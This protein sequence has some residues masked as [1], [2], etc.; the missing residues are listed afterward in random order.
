MRNFTLLTVVF[1]FIFANLSFSQ[2]MTITYH[3]DQPV[4]I[5][6]DD[7]YSELLFN[8]CYSFGEEGNPLLPYYGADLLLQQ[9]NEITNIEILST[10]YS[11]DIFDITIKPASKQFPISKGPDGEYKVVP[12]QD[13][14]SSNDPYP[15]EVI[16]NM[17][18]GFLAGHSIGSFSVCPV[19]YFPANNKVKF[20]EEITILI[21]TQETVKATNATAF[22]KQS[23][24]TTERI[25]KIV[26]NKEML[27]KYV[28]PSTKDEESDI[29]LITKN[30]L[31]SAFDDY[32]S[33]KES[34]GFIV[35]V[36]TTEEIYSQ[37]SGQDDQD[38]IRNC[39][40]D[41]YD[42]Y[43]LEYVILG[44]DSDPTNASQDIIP[45]R[46][47]FAVDDN[48]IPSDMYYCCL[49]GNW[50]DDGD[51]KWGEPGEYDLYA[52]V[53]IGRICVDN[54][55]EI[56]NFT[57]KLKMYQN[58]PVIQDTEKALMIGEELNNNPW[59]FGGDYKDEIAQGASN[60]GLVT[61]GISNNFEIDYL[62]ER[63]M[64]WNKYDVFDMF[65]N[66]GVNLL[67]H[68][69]HSSPD[70][71]MKMYTSD[72]TTNNFQNDGVTR[73][74]VIG[75]S[76][77]CYNGA[78]D[79]R[80]WNHY[81]GADCFAEKITTIATAE[82]ASVANSRYGW[83]QPGG[84]NSTSQLCDRQ[85]YDAIFGEDITIIGFTNSDSKEDLASNFSSSDY[86]RWTV[87]ELNLFGD[88]SMDIWTET[89]VDIIASYPSSLPIGS[90]EM[91]VQTDAPFARIGI[92]QNDELIGRAVAN[93]SGDATVEFI[94]PVTN[95][96]PIEISIIAHNKNRH[97]GSLV[98]VS[99]QPF[100]L[101]DSYEVNDPSG[102]GNG[103]I[104]FGE[105]IDLGLGVK[106]VGDQPASNVVVTLSSDCEYVSITD[107]TETYG[108]F[109]PGQTIFIDDAFA[110][111][112]AENI[113]DNY[114]IQFNV[115]AAGDSTWNSNFS[116][117]ACAPE[118]AL[119]DYIISDPDGNNN[120]RL[121][122]GETVNI[123]FNVE[124]IG[125]S[126]APGTMA[127]IATSSG[128]I[129]FNNATADL[130][131]LEAGESDE[132]IF[133]LTVDPAAPV[134]VIA[135]LSME[136]SS[137]YYSA[138]SDYF[139]K[140]GL[141]V[142]D[143][144]T[145]GF[146]QY[147]WQSGGHAD[148]EIT[149]NNPYEGTYCAKSGEID[150]NQFSILMLSYEAMFN[151]SIS[152][153][154]KVSSEANYDYLK[155]YID[156]DVVG[157]WA[158]NV[159]WQRVSFPISA[160]DHNLKW[161]YD[162]DTYVS[163]GAD[164]VWIDFVELP[165]PLVTTASA[166]MDDAICEGNTYL[167][168]GSA[169]NYNSV[170]WSTSGTGSF[171]NTSVL[172]PEYTP[173]N[174]DISNGS[175][176]LTLTVYGPGETITDNMQ[177][178][179]SLSPEISITGDAEICAND[180]FVTSN[181]SALNFNNVTWNTSGDGVFSDNTV[182]E[183]TYTSGTNDIENGMVTLT[184]SADAL[185]GC[186]DIADDFMLTIHP[187]PVVELG[188]D[189][190]ICFD[191]SIILD[192]GNPG[193]NYL[194]STNETT[195]T[196][197]ASS[198]GLIEIITYWAEVTDTFGCMD[199]DEITV[200]FEEC[201]GISENNNSRYVQ[202]VPNPNSG[203]FKIRC[204]LIIQNPVDVSV[205]NPLSGIVYERSDVKADQQNLLDIQLEEISSGIYFLRISNSEINL[206]KKIII[207][208]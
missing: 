169:T 173:S 42:S 52:E 137:G 80:D 20:L 148:W 25:N 88:P 104:D 27:E 60:N 204:D 121:D 14:Y 201:A 176:V 9:G 30:S 183:T 23:F 24:L 99:N 144:E 105:Q 10:T 142:E 197:E 206:I 16:E 89:P 8:D 7:G 44:G 48:D 29:L 160:G 200:S 132:A 38:K 134:G 151:D 189:T 73:G 138:Q 149:S 124:N 193:S 198:G 92:L 126:D 153:Y 203:S 66:S 72:I 181:V 98:V 191:Q 196:I 166:G 174:D 51:G 170:E 190:A 15:S 107:N 6:N 71:N 152:F 199:S 127:E 136:I 94:N 56:L 67:N 96:N 95:S 97:T 162:K 59:T 131:V 36:V 54:S 101:F 141:I 167:C 180:E 35:S 165:T 110:F 120:G 70:Y 125:Q 85:F 65:N 195:Q 86:M 178:D 146:G 159:P 154:V 77:G 164:C 147:E 34:T 123:I 61:T 130:E 90:F 187:L 177:L 208:D 202:I 39:I 207:Q 76:Q 26:E 194:W 184:I 57:H 4:I 114:N 133:S 31:V 1:S 2:E 78:M 115:E 43:N 63:D 172:N 84:T 91:A 47:F 188:S 116:I 122:P 113:P 45:H 171:S 205:Y 108:N 5:T 81:Y 112:V 140:I 69:G 119:G 100:V 117:M 50:N 145:G 156:S 37:Y 40:I 155:F 175:V 12:N 163:T 179:I 109:T 87:Y 79:N 103:L 182:L 53:G 106:N 185:E 111:T 11:K 143:W 46:G 150:D 118:L 55:T 32:V 158:G 74:Y 186:D 13:I 41:Y 192:A 102:N 128:Y 17:N 19:I 18:T 82:V 83:Y 161:F 139:A 93:A 157:Q 64:S 62:Y 33:F 58:D 68:L 49:D 21:T 129:T 75:Y 22:L 168:S 3:F 135:Q 28:Y